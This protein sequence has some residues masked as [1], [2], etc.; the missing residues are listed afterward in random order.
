MSV[1]G[2]SMAAI[3][4]SAATLESCVSGEKSP[5]SGQISGASSTISS[6]TSDGRLRCTGPGR[7]EAAIWIARA[8]SCPTVCADSAIQAALVTVAAISACGSSWKLPRPSSD[9]G[10]WPDNSTIGI[11]EACGVQSA[12]TAFVWPGPPVT[13]AI[14]TLP[15]S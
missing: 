8:S 10:A 15:V 3:A 11:S 7:P 12:A 9:V 4:A 14:P 13:I 5:T 2:A 1:I 6:S